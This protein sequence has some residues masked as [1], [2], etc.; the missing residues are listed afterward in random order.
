LQLRDGGDESLV[1]YRLCAL[2]TYRIP[3]SPELMD[4]NA[5]PKS[6]PGQAALKS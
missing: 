5:E 2:S 4:V 1:R 6:A 3:D